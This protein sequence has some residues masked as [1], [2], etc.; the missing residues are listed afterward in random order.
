MRS[1]AQWSIFQNT[2]ATPAMSMAPKSCSPQGSLSAL[3]CDFRRR[4]PGVGLLVD[5]PPADKRQ[6]GHDIGT[7]EYGWQ[8]KTRLALDVND[9]LKALS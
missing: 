9:L 6:I 5:L 3:N 8:T 4:R 2:L 7:A 1:S